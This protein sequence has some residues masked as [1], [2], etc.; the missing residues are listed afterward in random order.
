MR[1]LIGGR[2]GVLQVGQSAVGHELADGRGATL[3]GGQYLGER[4]DVPDPAGA[5]RVRQLGKAAD[6]GD[7]QVIGPVGGR[8]LGGDRGQDRDAGG[9]IAVD[10]EGGGVFEVEQHVRFVHVVPEGD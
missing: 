6:D 10:G 9:R 2:T 5:D 8:E 4:L 7:L 3:Q 1:A